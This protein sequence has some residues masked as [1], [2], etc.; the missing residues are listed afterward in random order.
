MTEEAGFR[1]NPALDAV[2]LAATFANG[3]RV[4]IG[5]FLDGDGAARLLVA[6]RAEQ[7]WRR[8]INGTDRVFET[9]SETYAL[10]PQAQRNTLDQAVFAAA[11][12]GFQFRYDAIR[13]P[14]DD[15]ERARSGTVL[16]GFARFM[17]T[18]ET[19]A[20][21]EEV[22]QRSGIVFADAQATRYLPGDFLTRHD[23]NVAGK[24]RSLAYVL[25]LS[26][27]WLPEWGGLLL[28]NGV[29][30]GVVETI[31]PRFNALSLFAVPQPHS[32]SFVA[33]YAPE[34]RLA[35]TGWLRTVRP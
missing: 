3:G 35:V 20:F 24:S 25:A 8:V 17:S 33:P 5:D 1:I 2:A 18:A 14:D 22:T 6:L 9:A 34:P 7:R 28:F 4:Q 12:R 23:D 29:E 26:P 21:L 30:S 32:V 19:L 15:T 16:D 10:M 11:A 13:V 27:E 31:V